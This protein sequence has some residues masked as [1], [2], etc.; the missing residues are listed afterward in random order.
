MLYAVYERKL[1]VYKK[2]IYT[3]YTVN[4]LWTDNTC[5]ATPHIMEQVLF[6]N[7]LHLAD[8]GGGNE[9]MGLPSAKMNTTVL[10]GSMP[11]TL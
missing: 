8:L 3:I 7:I 6:A 11:A 1:S 2:V 4:T 10:I 5:M 9:G